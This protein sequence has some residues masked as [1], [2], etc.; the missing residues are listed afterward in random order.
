MTINFL[1]N[2]NNMLQ[3]V[4]FAIFIN[5]NLKPKKSQFLSSATFVSAVS[6]MYILTLPYKSTIKPLLMCITFIVVII[7]MYKDSV[8]TKMIL[9]GMLIIFIFFSE[10]ISVLIFFFL[11]NYRIISIN[12]VTIQ[13][14]VS[15]IFF[16]LIFVS[17]S[18]IFN[19]FFNRLFN[20]V[21]IY[22]IALL[23]IMPFCYITLVMFLLYKRFDGISDSILIFIS[24]AMI[25]SVFTDIAIYHT[26]KTQTAIA[27]E[28]KDAVLMNAYHDMDFKYYELALAESKKSLKLKHDIM[29]YLQTIYSLSLSDNDINK[30]NGMEMVEALK[31]KLSDIHE[32]HYCEN[33]IV[34]I[35]LSLK[36]LEAQKEKIET[37]IAVSIPEVVP[38]E[39]MDLCSI[40]SNLYDNAIEACQRVE[41][42]RSIEIK[43][44]IKLNYL[45]IKFTNTCGEISKEQDG[46]LSTTKEDRSNHGLGLKIVKEIVDKYNG[47]FEY[48][49]DNFCFTATVTLQEND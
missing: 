39:K 20:R 44:R 21:K 32:T 12:E 36:T 25:I 27:E 43:A 7:L 33:N 8:K 2:I 17:I 3:S 42:E 47:M 10:A 37:Q 16:N 35:V 30:K 18:T 40:F 19:L 49:N 48:E 38:F 26:V 6:L 1:T 13:R 5:G 46:L 15:S 14:L 45:I 4:L 41:G 29:N 34:N 23:L 9:T 24:V 28:E 11:S 31:S 22:L